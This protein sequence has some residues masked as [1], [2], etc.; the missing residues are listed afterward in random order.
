MIESHCFA[1]FFQGEDGI[2][3]YKVNGVQKCALPILEDCADD[4]QSEVTVSLRDLRRSMQAFER[5]PTA[6]YQ[7]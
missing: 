1:F 7:R 2:R 5:L 4:I 6:T 3:D